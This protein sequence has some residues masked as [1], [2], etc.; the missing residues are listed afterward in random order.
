M[1][2]RSDFDVACCWRDP[3][4]CGFEKLNNGLETATEQRCYRRQFVSGQR[5]RSQQAQR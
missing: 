4:H 1:L 3:R 2:I 5:W